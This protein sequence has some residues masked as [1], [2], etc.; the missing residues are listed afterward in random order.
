MRK[1]S[2]KQKEQKRKLKP[3]VK[4]ARA[5]GK[6]ITKITVEK[7]KLKCFSNFHAKRKE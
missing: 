7:R 6:G 1:I 2:T 5:I 3:K 4:Y